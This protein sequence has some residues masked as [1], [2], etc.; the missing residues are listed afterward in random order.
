[1]NETSKSFQKFNATGR[2]LLI[3]F[4]PPVEDVEL[5]VYLNECI[6][7]LTYYLVNDVRDRDLVG[8]RVR[9]TECS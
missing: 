9:K 5:T 3:K 2:N 7:G 8:L 1:L 4:M 6:T